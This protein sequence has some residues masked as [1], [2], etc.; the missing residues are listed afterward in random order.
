MNLKKNSLLFVAVVSSFNICLAQS[1]VWEVNKDGNILYLGGS[2]HTLRAEDFPL[3]KEFDKAFEQSEM[4]VLEADVEQASSPEAT[5]KLMAKAMLPGEET[6]QT[7]LNEDT[8]KKLEAK[9][10]ELSL[11]IASVMKLKPSMVA[12]ILTMLEIQQ[13]GF[14]PQGVDTYYLTQA[15][16]KNKKIDFLESV[17]FQIELL[18]NLGTG[19]ENEYI[20]Y[21]VE[22]LGN[23]AKE[24]EQ[25]LPDWKN[26]TSIYV[27]TAIAEMKNKFPK[28]YNSTLPERNNAWLPKIE[29]YLSDKTGAFVVVGLMHL[30]GEDGLLAQLQSKGYTV[31]QVQ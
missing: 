30:L 17:D 1:S 21:T 4:L 12:T 8:Y 28:A 31:K 25:L 3:P 29:N 10:N 22:E 23:T 18:A 26:G 19:Y 20:Q 11:P 24:M 2:I 14:T 5:Q 15:K 16:E 13:L 6:L 9:C 27:E 7:I